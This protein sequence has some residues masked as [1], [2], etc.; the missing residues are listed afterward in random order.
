MKVE[1]LYTLEGRTIEQV[2]W[3]HYYELG[4]IELLL[5]DGREIKISASTFM[6]DQYSSSPMLV[7]KEI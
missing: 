1:E 7:V 3:H 5:D 6:P 4:H 2:K